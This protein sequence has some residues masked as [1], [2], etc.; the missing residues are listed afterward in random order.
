ME[1]GNTVSQN[2]TIDD[3]VWVFPVTPEGDTAIEVHLKYR[4]LFLLGAVLTSLGSP[5]R[6]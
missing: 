6:L 5:V 4:S 2:I 3:E 1:F